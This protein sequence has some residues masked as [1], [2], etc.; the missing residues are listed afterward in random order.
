MELGGGSSGSDVGVMLGC[1]ARTMR[2]AGIGAD[3]VGEGGG[4]SL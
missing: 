4:K 1:C 3:K 2:D